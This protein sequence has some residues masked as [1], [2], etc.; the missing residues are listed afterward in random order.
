MC[1]CKFSE[2]CPI[3]KKKNHRREFNDGMSS[4]DDD[5]GDQSVKSRKKIS[6]YNQQTNAVFA[7]QVLKMMSLY[8]NLNLNC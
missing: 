2:K 7:F 3:Y 8:G 4:D 1:S 5:D 6:F